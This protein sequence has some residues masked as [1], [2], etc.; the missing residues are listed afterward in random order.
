VPLHFL[1]SRFAYAGM[2]LN[3]SIGVGNILALRGLTFF[4][5]TDQL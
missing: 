5:F 4:T 3:V 2:Q 1:H